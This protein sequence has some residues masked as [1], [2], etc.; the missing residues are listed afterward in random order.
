MAYQ[1]IVGYLKREHILDRKRLLKETEVPEW[2][3]I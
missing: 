1:P 2:N 3:P